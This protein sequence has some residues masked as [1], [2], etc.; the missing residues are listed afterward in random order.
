MIQVVNQLTQK[1]KGLAGMIRNPIAWKTSLACCYAFLLLLGILPT[2]VS[3]ADEPGLEKLSFLPTWRPQ[4]QFAGYY[5]ALEKGF[6]RQEGIDLTIIPGGPDRSPKDYL[7]HRKADIVSMWLSTA[8]QL[9]ADGIDIGHIA[10][11]I[12]RS[13]LM[14]VAGTDSG[15]HS[16]QDMDGKRVAMWP[17]DFQIQPMALF[18]RHGL[19]V[20]PITLAETLNLFLRGGADVALIMWYNEYNALRMYGMDPDRMHAVFFSDTDL[21]FPEDGLYVLGDTWFA[22]ENTLCRFVKAS[23][24]GWRYAFKH[25]DEAVDIVLAVMRREQVPASRSHQRWM[26]SC[27][28]SLIQ[29]ST[30]G[31]LGVLPEEDYLRVARVLEE[32]RRISGTPNFHYFSKG[33][34]SDVS[35]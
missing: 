14:M 19:T 10:Q 7:V 9:A 12:Q 23:F 2:V 31:R 4:A 33:C 13:A 11:V 16:L 26:L 25:P 29:P 15:I 5:V 28:Q 24:E 6:Y 34:M 30:S 20:R 32:G 8:V 21:N 17:S 35:K 1:C 27:M 3:H 22:R 18:E